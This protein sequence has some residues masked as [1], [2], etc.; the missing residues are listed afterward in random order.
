MRRLIVGNGFVLKRL[1]EILHHQDLAIEV[2]DQS[3]AVLARNVFVDK[4]SGCDEPL[5]D[6]D[7]LEVNPFL[8]ENLESTK[9]DL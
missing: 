1:P 4:F 5:I 3:N 2:F 7:T 8:L 6:K 9:Y